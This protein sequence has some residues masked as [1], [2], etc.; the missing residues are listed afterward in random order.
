MEEKCYTLK[1]NTYDDLCPEII[2]SDILEF[3][4]AKRYFYYTTN[5][6]EVNGILR[7]GIKSIHRL[8]SGSTT[9]VEIKMKK[10]K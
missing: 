1:I 9:W 7:S 8:I 5:S 3:V 4:S 2:V 6:G 10:F